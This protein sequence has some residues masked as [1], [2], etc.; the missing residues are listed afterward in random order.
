MNKTFLLAT[1]MNEPDERLKIFAQIVDNGW[2][3]IP[4][5]QGI[6]RIR[7]SSKTTAA[8]FIFSTVAK[9]A[10]KMSF[11]QSLEQIRLWLKCC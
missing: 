11:L 3:L 6:R 9:N 8:N 7:K 1:V 10:W 2:Y 4:L 5:H